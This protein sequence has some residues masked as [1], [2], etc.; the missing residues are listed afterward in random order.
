[1]AKAELVLAESRTADARTQSSNEFWTSSPL[2]PL[3]EHVKAE[4]NDRWAIGIIASLAKA[5]ADSLNLEAAPAATARITQL[6]VLADAYARH[7]LKQEAKPTHLRKQA[8]EVAFARAYEEGRYEDAVLWGRELVNIKR[9]AKDRYNLGLAY[10][11]LGQLADAARE[12]ESSIDCDGR[13]LPPYVSLLK[14]CDRLNTEPPPGLV[15]RAVVL[16]KYWQSQI[17]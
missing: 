1:L 15:Q 3:L 10:G 11:R 12:F 13:Y 5:E 17:E 8:L 16:S 14:L 4:P 9:S 7:A 2:K 6:H